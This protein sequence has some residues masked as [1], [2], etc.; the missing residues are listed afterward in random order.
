MKSKLRPLRF[1]SNASGMEAASVAWEPLGWE[2]VGLCDFGKLQQEVLKHHYPT[3]PL[4]TNMLNLLENENFKKTNYDVHIAGTPCQAFS[5]SGLRNGMD[6]DRAQLAI[7]NGNIITEKS[8]WCFLW[9]NVV[10]VFDKQHREGLRQILS[11]FTGCDIRAEDIFEGGGIIQGTKYSVAYRVLDSQYFGVPQR[12]RRIYVV[13]FRGSDWRL[14]A[15]VLFN[16]SSFEES[17]VSYRKKRD[18]IAQN[19]LGQIK[20]AGTITRTFSISQTDGFGQLS[21]SNYWPDDR[22][23]R[24]F[25][26]RE[27]LKIQGFPEDYLDMEINGKKLTYSQVKALVG[28]SMT[29]PVIRTIG[30]RI[31]FVYEQMSKRKDFVLSI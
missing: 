25:T 9:E 7:T 18:E 28:N 27:L 15:A 31:Q 17:K 4:Y 29:V 10:G 2:C 13:G 3:V 23:I 20:L 5:D 11:N 30:E 14:A 12:R 22:G 6:D 24:M 19:I 1:F 16:Q 8:P 26:E 21:T